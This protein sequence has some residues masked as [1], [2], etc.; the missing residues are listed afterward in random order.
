[1]VVAAAAAGIDLLDADCFSRFTGRA[2]GTDDTVRTAGDESPRCGK[3]LEVL[4]IIVVVLPGDGDAVCATIVRDE[5]CTNECFAL[6]ESDLLGEG[7]LELADE[8]EDL[9]GNAVKIPE[10][11]FL[12]LGAVDIA[13]TSVRTVFEG[14]CDG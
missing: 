4:A 1:M 2:T 7:C 12:A 8:V 6:L 11:P 5:V 9:A 13:W 10:A 3:V 14:G